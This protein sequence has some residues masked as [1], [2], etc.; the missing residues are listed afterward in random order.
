MSTPAS[1]GRHPIHPML[2]TIPIGLWSFSF[3]SDVIFVAGWGRPIW[4]DVA[5][6]TLIGGIVGALLAAAP[7]FVD[8]LA[9]TTPTVKRIATIH[10][11][12]NLGIVAL[13]GVNAWLRIASPA[14]VT[15]PIVLSMVG[16]I[17]LGIS[18]WLGGEMVYVHGVGVE[19][20][21]AFPPQRTRRA[22]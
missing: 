22:A 10:M 4:N 2:V 20:E 5:F 11:V 7:G 12:I 15:L 21:D 19:R 17:L 6:Y 13:F 16:L 14:G 3:V 9:L 18:G 1:V 8:W